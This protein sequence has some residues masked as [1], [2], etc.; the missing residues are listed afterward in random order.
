MK[1]LIIRTGAIFFLILTGFIVYYLVWIKF[2]WLMVVGAIIF[3]S[4]DFQLAKRGRYRD[5]K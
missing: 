2:E 4:L 1:I 3:A 5:N